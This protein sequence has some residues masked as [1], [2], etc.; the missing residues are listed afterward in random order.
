MRICFSE[1]RDCTTYCDAVSINF[2]PDYEFPHLQS[3]HIQNVIYDQYI[4]PHIKLI[5]TP[6]H[7]DWSE[8]C[9]QFC[10]LPSP[11]LS[12][13]GTKQRR[14]IFHSFYLLHAIITNNAQTQSTTTHSNPPMLASIQA[15]S[16]YHARSSAPIPLVRTPR[17]R[18]TRT[19]CG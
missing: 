5:V 11:M 14:N 10:M 2:P 4:Y 1:Y 18:R 15:H 12:G 7:P 3:L 8:C 9:H 16:R 17:R 13:N 19:T 6:Y